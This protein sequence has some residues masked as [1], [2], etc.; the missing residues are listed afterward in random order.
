MRQLE[1]KLNNQRVELTNSDDLGLRL[2]RLAQSADNLAVKGSDFSTTVTIPKTKNNNRLFVNKDIL[3]GLN[4]FNALSDYIAEIS[5]DG[6]RILYGTF[7]LSRITRDSYEGELKSDGSD[8][9]GLL[10]QI[11]LNEL[12]YVDG[13]PTWFQ[14]FE[15]AASI[16]LYN[17][18]ALGTY[19]LVFPTIVYNN[20][21]LT[22]YY[23]LSPANV[24]GVYD[25]ADCTELTPRTDYPNEFSL[26]NGYFGWREGLTFEDF[27]GAIHY[28]TLILKAFE[29][30]GWNVKGQI[31]NEDWFNALIMPYVGEEFN[32]NYKTLGEVAVDLTTNTE[33]AA[34]VFDAEDYQNAAVATDL[35]LPAQRFITHNPNVGKYHDKATR[36]DRI[37]AFGK[38]LVTDD[39]VGDYQAGGYIAPTTGRY[40]IRVKSYYEKNLTPVDAAAAAF[41][42][43]F[44]N[45]VANYGWDDNVLVITRRDTDGRF[46][47]T[48]NTGTDSDTQDWRSSA[49]LWM[50]QTN[51]DFITNPSDV[52]AYISPKRYNAVGATTESVG[53]PLSNFTETVQVDLAT[54][55]ITN[56]TTTDKDSASSVDIT[57]EIDL[58]KNERVN[59][60]WTSLVQIDAIP[61][62]YK[63]NNSDTEVNGTAFG[64]IEVDYLCGYADLDI[65]SNLP[66]M[67]AK[68]FISSFINQFNL[69]FTVEDASK[70]VE[71]TL[72]DTFYAPYTEA[73][74]ITSRVDE[75]SL[76]INPLNTPKNLVIGYDN[77]LDDRLLTR[78]T[79][80]CN[81][82]SE[83]ESTNYGNVLLT[84]NDNIYSD[85]ELQIK[86][87]F[88]ATRF[89]DGT[90][91]L[92][93]ITSGSTVGTLVNP[94]P[95]CNGYPASITSYWRFTDGEVLYYELPSIQSY[96][97]YQQKT[98]QDLEYRYDY[99]PRILYFLGTA[100]DYLGADPNNRIKI[101]SRGPGFD[102]EDFAVEPTVCSFDTENNNPYPSL[103]YDT[104]LYDAY[105]ENL[106][107]YFNKSYILEAKIA[108]RSSD[109]NNLRANRLIRFND[110]LY[111]LLEISEFDPL[112]E[113]YA[114]IVM[115]KVI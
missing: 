107:E 101:D 59:F 82:T 83:R 110:N 11:Q 76:I 32:Y 19:P 2:N 12:G 100:A 27:P 30:I 50:N 28:K 6:E 84:P 88:S 90:L 87:M 66:E 48:Y 93:D 10:D 108:L 97:S 69:R 96:D 68:E 92:M 38:Y 34:T 85:G 54:H 94:Y 51:N 74:D 25:P 40:R 15:G 57:I 39:A 65:A 60:Y 70:T 14:P 5:V 78:D 53:S 26:L 67:G 63:V 22:D 16:N 44:G 13:V 91:E 35:T 46:K 20:T 102:D 45:S 71:F 111:R 112:E 98:L 29:E 3:G 73:Y 115:M 1:L 41:I 72:P 43:T 58:E 24:F 37:A 33:S 52:I 36:L 7:R 4:K 42:D 55:V 75:D 114:T 8:W 62:S 49:V 81:F 18:S 106:I 113:N 9:I 21:P 64:E 109:W 105:F 17:N 89:V 79:D 80:S 86:T 104:Y 103:R 47:F 99:T 31:F 61:S 56:N 95:E 23:N 77:D